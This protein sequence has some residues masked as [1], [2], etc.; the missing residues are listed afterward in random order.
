M[1]ETACVKERLCVCVCVCLHLHAVMIP[2]VIVRAE[3]CMHGHAYLSCE[4]ESL[5]VKSVLFCCL[6]RKISLTKDTGWVSL[7]LDLIQ[8]LLLVADQLK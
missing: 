4:S 8:H 2:W 1:C 6:V 7:S 5:N 3:E